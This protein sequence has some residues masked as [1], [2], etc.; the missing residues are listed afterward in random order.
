MLEYLKD[1]G[2]VKINNFFDRYNF[3]QQIEY[4]HSSE[5]NNVR[6]TYRG[7]ESDKYIFYKRKG[8]NEPI[9]FGEESLGNQNLLRMLPSFLEVVENGGMLLIDE[10]SSGFHNDLESM[11]IKYFHKESKNSQMIFVSHSTNLLSNSLLRPDQEY[12]VEFQDKN[13]SKVKRFSTEQPR[14]AQNIEKMYTSG[15][16]GGLPQFEEV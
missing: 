12:T 1:N 16:F 6:I 15:V 8:I 5:G 10:F 7:D 13:G 9:P 11:L 3:K 4:A 14:S 2:T